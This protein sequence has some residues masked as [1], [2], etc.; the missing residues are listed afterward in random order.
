MNKNFYDP[1]AGHM[2]PQHKLEIWPGYVT[3]VQDFEGGVMLCCD[4]SHKVLRTQTAYDLI[5]DIIAQKLPDMQAAVTKS[6]LG[7]VILTRY[8]NKCYRVDDIDWTM[9]P[10]S[11][12]TDHTGEEKSF[13]DYYK[14]QYNI[15][16]KD[17]KQ[18]MLISRAKKKT[19]E[20]ADVAKLIA[21]V[22]ELCNM[23]GLTDQMKADFRVMKDV[24]QFTRVTPNQRQQALKKFINNVNNSAEAS[25]VLLNWGRE[26]TNNQMLT[27]VDLK[28]WSVVYVSKNEAVAQNFVSLMTKLA[29]KMGMK[30]AQPEMKSLANDRTETYLK[31]IREGVNP[32]IQMVVA[33][34]PTPRDDRYSA[35]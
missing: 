8:N 22:P 28:K 14:K 24:A 26:S 11:K 33:I 9:T 10:S 16:I 12:F 6:L 35:G 1:R 5:K 34:M 15:A 27:A 17:P 29:P 20:E 13:V 4:V 2:V 32:T 30:V 3:A 23:T 25:S 7:A 18:P 31:T 21:L 19:H